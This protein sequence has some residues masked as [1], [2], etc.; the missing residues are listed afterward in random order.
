MKQNIAFVYLVFHIQ[1][2]CLIGIRRFNLVSHSPH[3][4][5]KFKKGLRGCLWW[6]YLWL[7]TPEQHNRMFPQPV[8]IREC[9][10]WKDQIWPSQSLITWLCMP[11]ANQN[12]RYIFFHYHEFFNI[13]DTLNWEIVFPWTILIVFFFT[14]SFTKLIYNQP[15]C[16]KVHTYK[17]TYIHTQLLVWEEDKTCYNSNMLVLIITLRIAWCYWN[18]KVTLI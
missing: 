10:H 18:H 4:Q 3:F 5:N 9:N 8:L 11:I 1:M 13:M 2:T 16:S 12:I 14:F 15:F 7:C 17:C 6:Q